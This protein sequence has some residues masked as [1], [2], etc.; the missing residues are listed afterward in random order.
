MGEG[1]K[2]RSRK[3]RKRRGLAKR[4][5]VV[6]GR[7]RPQGRGKESLVVVIRFIYYYFCDRINP[8][9]RPAVWNNL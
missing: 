2:E 4:G 6:G 3:E 1:G 7:L 8:I 9:A 5:K